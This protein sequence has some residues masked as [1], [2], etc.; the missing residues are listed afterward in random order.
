ML[1]F[2][3]LGGS[4]ITQ[5]ARAYTARRKTLARLAAEVAAAQRENPELQLVLGHG[6]GSFG[7]VAAQKHGTRHGVQGAAQWAGFTEVWRQARALD[8]IVLDAF[9]QTGL[10]VMAFPA[11]AACIA[12]QGKVEQWHVTPI[13][14]ALQSGLIPVIYGDVIFDTQMGGTILSTEE[15]FMH[16][17]RELAPQRILLAG[18]EPGV[19][20]DYPQRQRLVQT[21]THQTYQHYSQNVGG[22]WAVDVTGGM[23]KKVESMLRICAEVPG[24]QAL[25]F[26]GNQEQAVYRALLGESPGTI[27]FKD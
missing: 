20:A 4:L 5:K 14:R 11:S 3:K 27:I 6:S 21:L 15:L 26:S 24:L 25:I 1:Y 22:S 23:A 9:Q 2:L 16:L 10:P 8:Q 7:H 18:N 12:N 17:A 13:R 19:W